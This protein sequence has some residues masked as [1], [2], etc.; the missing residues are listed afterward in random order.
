MNSSNNPF[1]RRVSEGMRNRG[2]TLRQFCREVPLDP[3]FFS[4]VLAGKRSPPSSEDVLRRIARLL[5]LGE[6]QLIVAAGRIPSE[7][8][9]L[10]EDARLFQDVNSLANKAAAPPASYS[11]RMPVAVKR[12]AGDLAEELL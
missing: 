5:S 4:K 8:G 10:C 3:S 12:P 7:W 2:L 9:A 1:A 11:R 6:T